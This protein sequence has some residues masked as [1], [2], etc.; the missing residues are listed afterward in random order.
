MI[1]VSTSV[2]AD[3]ESSGIV[4]CVA[5][6][7]FEEFPA[8]SSLNGKAEWYAGAIVEEPCTG[9]EK[10]LPLAP[11]GLDFGSASPPWQM[12]AKI[13]KNCDTDPGWADWR[14]EFIVEIRIVDATYQGRLLNA[15]ASSAT[16]HYN[17]A[18]ADFGRSEDFA[19]LLT[20][21]TWLSQSFVAAQA[22]AAEWG[23]NELEEQ[24]AVRPVDVTLSYIAV[25]GDDHLVNI[26]AQ[27]EGTV[28]FSGPSL[29]EIEAWSFHLE[30][31]VIKKGIVEAVLV[32][33]GQAWA[34]SPEH[35]RPN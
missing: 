33:D 31:S 7:D 11:V 4:E 20:C 26:E 29:I 3:G 5:K 15:I 9:V 27:G 16:F 18:V 22:Q 30:A 34:L 24:G 1:L 8:L 6:D 28:T 35:I 10:P 23:A 32:G 21:Q 2:Q 17:D 25:P 14:G 12:T 19:N 13:V